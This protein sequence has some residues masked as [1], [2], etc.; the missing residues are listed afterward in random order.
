MKNLD[1]LVIKEGHWTPISY[2][3]DP[4]KRSINYHLKY[5]FINLDK[6]SNPSSHEVVSW[7]KRILKVAKTGHSGTLDPK[8]TGV[9][10][11][12]IESAT[13]LAKSQQNA[14]KEYYSIIKLNNNM[15]ADNP[16]SELKKKVKFLQG[17]IFQ[18][19]PAISAVKKELRVRHIY[20]S[21]VLE[22]N[23]KDNTGII[24]VS[25]EAGT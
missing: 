14:G 22:F 6:P 9:L 23:E 2:G 10:I 13:R 7:V 24:W 19:P 3:C 1:K 16:L 20:D 11:I 21:K 8:V 18:K 5:G 12:C 15:T 25:V 4:L 17:A